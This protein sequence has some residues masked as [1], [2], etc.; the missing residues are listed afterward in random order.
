LEEITMTLRNIRTVIGG[1]VVAALAAAPVAAQEPAAARAGPPSA[2]Q[3]PTFQPLPPEPDGLTLT[4]FIGAG[5][6]GNLESTPAALG[7]ALGYGWSPRVALEGELGLSP[8]ASMGTPLEFDT[9]VWTLSGNILYHFARQ[10]VSPYVTLGL[11]VMGSNPDVPTEVFPDLDQRTTT[12]A[13]NIGAGVKTAV[14]DRFGLRADL[15]HF[16]AS[17]LAPDYWRVYGGVVIR[18][19]GR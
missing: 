19:L 4:P 13:W 1:I 6:S 9:S 8:N 2:S 14:S 18:H 16:N 11:G 3:Q 12:F 15:R 7:L 17:D 5:F 10:S